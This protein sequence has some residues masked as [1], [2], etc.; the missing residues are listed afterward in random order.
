MPLI[1]EVSLNGTKTLA[2]YAVRRL[3]NTNVVEPHG[4]TNTYEIRK[5]NLVNTWS[6]PLG[7][8]HHNYD[9]PVEK[10]VEL[11]MKKIQEG[12]K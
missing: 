9:D 11:T 6:K 8:I 2:C 3:T 4:T 12:K 5:S 10:I 1:I 7:H